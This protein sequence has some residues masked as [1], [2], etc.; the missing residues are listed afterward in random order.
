MTAQTMRAMSR[1]LTGKDQGRL[2]ERA[3]V[4][5]H[6]VRVR[7]TLEVEPEHLEACRAV[8]DGLIGQFATTQHVNAARKPGG[9]GGAR[10][11]HRQSIEVL[12]NPA[13][14]AAL[15]VLLF[16]LARSS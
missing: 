6:L 13:T 12:R 16:I 10:W 1:L 3:D 9:T 2:E 15:F 4:V 14:L 7:D 5:A 8:V 11:D